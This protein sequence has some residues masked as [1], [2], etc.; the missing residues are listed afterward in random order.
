MGRISTKYYLRSYYWNQKAQIQNFFENVVPHL[1]ITNKATSY[2]LSYTPNMFSYFMKLIKDNKN[3]HNYYVKYLPL[4]PL[5][6]L[7]EKELL[8]VKREKLL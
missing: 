4:F 5:V 8:A 1:K 6:R 2:G 7:R 3:F